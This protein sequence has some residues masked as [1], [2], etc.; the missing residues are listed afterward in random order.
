[1]AGLKRSLKP[2][3]NNAGI[4]TVS[5]VAHVDADTLAD[6]R[7]IGEKTAKMLVLQAKSQSTGKIIR[8]KTPELSKSNVEMY[9]DIESEPNLDCDYLHGLLIVE[10]GKKDRYLSFVA[11][12]PDQEEQTFREF[13]EAVKVILDKHPKTPIY[14]YHRYENIHVHKLF[15]KYPD[16]SLSEDEL[17]GDFVDL[18]R[19]LTE[20]FI[21][22]VE[23]YGL[24]PFSK[25]LG[26]EYRNTKSSAV[27]SMLWYR[28]W[29]DTGD[30]QYLDDS[31]IYNEDD[32][33]A[34]KVVRDWL[35]ST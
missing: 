4:T 5:K 33:R 8:L 1:M 24:K 9:Y 28:L 14:H 18:H 25:Y 35:V 19:K 21:L 23:G 12:G 6:F 11:D 17:M 2:Q 10:D 3:L 34:T 26:F 30:R 27:Q 15:E 22:P 32:C 31:I 7:G 13:V 16:Q 20:S 29:L